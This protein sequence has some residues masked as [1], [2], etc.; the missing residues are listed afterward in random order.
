[1]FHGSQVR[2]T[3]SFDG[4]KSFSY[5]QVSLFLLPLLEN[6]SDLTKNIKS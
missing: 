4:D 6:T 5:L 1:M 3:A 2:V